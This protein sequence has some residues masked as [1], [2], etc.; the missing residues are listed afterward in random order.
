M[1]RKGKKGFVCDYF[2][3]I[4][5]G[6]IVCKELEMG[7]AEKVYVK[8]MYSHYS[9]PLVL[10]NPECIGKVFKLIIKPVFLIRE[11]LTSILKKNS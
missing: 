11:I 1:A 2:L 7:K 3:R 9:I 8:A 10:K 5:K 4:E 6:N